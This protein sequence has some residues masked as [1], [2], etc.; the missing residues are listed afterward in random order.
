MRERISYA[1]NAVEIIPG[2]SVD[3]SDK[4]R[5]MYLARESTECRVFAVNYFLYFVITY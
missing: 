4:I 5:Q 2:R 1:S 3:N